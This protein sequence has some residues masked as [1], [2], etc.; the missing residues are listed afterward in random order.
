MR[1][2]EQGERGPRRVDVPFVPGAFALVDVL[3]NAEC[4]DLIDAAEAA[5]YSPDEPVSA[6][7]SDSPRAASLVW[8]ADED[9]LDRIYSRCRRLLPA[10]LGGGEL[11][12]INARWRLYR[13][14]QEAV[15][16]PHV[17]GAWPG[18]GRVDGKLE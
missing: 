17:D 9:T 10:Q 12:G 11:A 8:L 5:G 13:Y 2:Q 18:S 7:G 15:Y 1:W 16:R 4:A 3:S 6:A 14:G